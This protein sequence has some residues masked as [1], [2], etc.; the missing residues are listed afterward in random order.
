MTLRYALLTVTLL[1]V[2]TMFANEMPMLPGCWRKSL[3][4]PR[5]TFLWLMLEEAT[6]RWSWIMKLS[7]YVVNGHLFWNYFAHS[8]YRLM[9]T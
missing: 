5:Q 7:L 1:L 6:D 4:F 8:Y 2:R 9:G 3:C